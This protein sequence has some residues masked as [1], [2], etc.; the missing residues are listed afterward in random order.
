M[1][2][3]GTRAVVHEKPDQRASWVHHGTPAWYIGLY[4]ENCRTMKFYM[5]TTSF[6]R[7]T[8]TLQFI[9]DTFKCPETTA[10]D[11]LRQ[12]FGGIIA[13]LQDPPKTLPFLAYGDDN[14]NAIK[15]SSPTPT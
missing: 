13:L 8:D 14:K 7:Y 9:P 1:S 6:V 11:Y 2:P 12:S 4:L 3:P 15:N 10:E 5:P